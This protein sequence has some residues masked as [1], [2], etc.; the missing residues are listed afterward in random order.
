[1]QAEFVERIRITSKIF[2]YWK[3]RL[4]SAAG[5]SLKL[6]FK[7]FVIVLL[8]TPKLPFVIIATNSP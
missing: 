8:P 2:T 1:L 4:Q 5:V 3:F 7:L 6:M